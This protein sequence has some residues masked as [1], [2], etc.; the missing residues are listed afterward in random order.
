[1]FRK[2]LVP[3]DLSHVQKDSTLVELAH[4]FANKHE[5]ELTLLNVVP[6]GSHHVVIEVLKDLLEKVVSAAETSLRDIAKKHKLA[7][8][9][10]IRLNMVTRCGKSSRWQLTLTP[11][12]Y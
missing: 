1:M 2:I 7:A 5:C 3:I 9:T 10:K 12:S 8:S 6:E 4:E 11:I